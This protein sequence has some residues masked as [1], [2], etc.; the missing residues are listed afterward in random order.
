MKK[1]MTLVMA[2]C[3][4][5]LAG[6]GALAQEIAISCVY[7]DGTSVPITDGATVKSDGELNIRLDGVTEG[8]IYRAEL[9]GK[10]ISGEPFTDYQGFI[11]DADEYAN[12]IYLLLTDK[13]GT[14]GPLDLTLTGNGVQET[15][16][17]S[18]DVKPN[19]E[20]DWIAYG[21]I[22]NP[23]M[24]SLP[25]F[26]AV[27]PG[28][29]NA[30]AMSTKRVQ[31]VEPADGA[32]FSGYSFGEISF[33]YEILEPDTEIRFKIMD[34]KTDRIVYE[35]GDYFQ[36]P[37]TRGLILEF[38]SCFV[39]DREYIFEITD[40][41][42]T[43]SAR[44]TLVEEEG[45][46]AEGA[47][48]IMDARMKQNEKYHH[49]EA[50]PSHTMD[51]SS[52]AILDGSARFE[53]VKVQKKNDP[54]AAGKVYDRLVEEFNASV[55]SYT[56]G[57]NLEYGLYKY[58]NANDSGGI[59]QSWA[60]AGNEKTM[61]VPQ[62]D[63]ENAFKDLQGSIAIGFQIA[64]VYQ[65]L[66]GDSVKLMK[67]PIQL[68]RISEKSSS[69]EGSLGYLLVAH[70]AF[71]DGNVFMGDMMLYALKI[72]EQVAEDHRYIYVRFADP[73]G[74]G[75]QFYAWNIADQQLVQE[76]VSM[77]GGSQTAQDGAQQETAQEEKAQ[78][79]VQIRKDGS[80]NVRQKSNA[81]SKRVGTAK[82]N[83]KYPCLS[84]AK[85][86]WFEIQLEDGTTGF[87]SPKMA[88]LLD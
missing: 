12:Y 32:V 1:A 49:E 79:Y 76:I 39:F 41:E 2:A 46:N 71:S 61:Q 11:A 6:C 28:D 63:P 9:T 4:L 37:D 18:V 84:V 72:N 15:I 14:Y 82:A 60:M 40:G 33:T 45:G 36:M 80:V 43:A 17:F 48:Q 23:A 59:F 83:A 16:S 31:I 29:E 51:E 35:G 88:K 87:V 86:G 62:P 26:L 57:M 7:D 81:D 66:L 78:R 75:S 30:P 85:N 25:P 64:Q 10:S 70:A 69:Q 67:L 54:S 53:F 50:V 20:K 65:Q 34:T 42:S 56:T 27:D 13:A 24:A 3:L 58:D 73:L 77:M 52:Q 74:D 5:M 55:G 22:N 38:E 21:V 19:S 68:H 47:Q 8:M 44:F